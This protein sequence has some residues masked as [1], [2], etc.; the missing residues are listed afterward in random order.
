[1]SQ[2]PQYAPAYTCAYR[3]LYSRRRYALR[4]IRLSSSRGRHCLLQNTFILGQYSLFSPHRITAYSRY[5]DIYSACR[6]H[7]FRATPKVPAVDSFTRFRAARA[8]E[9]GDEK[10]CRH[11][12]FRARLFAADTRW[13]AKLILISAHRTHDA[14]AV[15]GH[16]QRAR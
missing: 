12:L 2:Q 5:N 7:E 16:T 9:Y 10:L 13:A 11:L 3:A 6:R 8:D 1:M 15:P 4:D 14:K